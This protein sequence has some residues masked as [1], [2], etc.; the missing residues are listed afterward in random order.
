MRLFHKTDIILQLYLMEAMADFNQLI[1]FYCPE[2]S[3]FR[4]LLNGQ[5]IYHQILI[6]EQYSLFSFSIYALF[7]L[8]S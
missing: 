2:T 4:M 8:D 3:L 5:V 7:Q 1:R 6:M